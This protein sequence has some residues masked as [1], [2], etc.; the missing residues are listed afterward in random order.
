MTAPDTETAERIAGALVEARLAAC[1]NI[2]PGVRSVYRWQGAIE[3]AEEISAIF[4]TTAALAEA[5]SALIVRLHPYEVPCIVSLP[6]G[7][8]GSHPGYL[9]W[10]G[11]ETRP[12]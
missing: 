7:E 10:I 11:Q 5:A 2:F 8:A 9:S 1:A 12:G 3:S 4:K 6:I